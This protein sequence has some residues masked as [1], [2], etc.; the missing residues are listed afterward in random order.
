M[1]EYS[2]RGISFDNMC[3]MEDEN[4]FLLEKK[5]VCWFVFLTLGSSFPLQN[6]E[7][8]CPGYLKCCVELYD[9]L[10]LMQVCLFFR[11]C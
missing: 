5:N 9:D 8:Y 3:D 6:V 10:I 2:H 1:Q 7:L 11:A 4:F